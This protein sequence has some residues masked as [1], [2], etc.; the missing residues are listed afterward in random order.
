MNK[1]YF[2]PTS[3]IMG[4]DCVINNSGVFE[5]LGGKAL[6]VTGSNS[7]KRNGLE[8]DIKA[9]LDS[10]GISYLVYDRV[11][12]NP[13]ISCVYKGAAVTREML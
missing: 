12:S 7:A 4:T 5:A 10:V 8:Q 6:I 2:M 3:V 13:T 9:A 11:M 1:K